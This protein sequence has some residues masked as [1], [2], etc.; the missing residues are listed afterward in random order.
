MPK[1]YFKFIYEKFGG[2]Y[3]CGVYS[4]NHPDQTFAK[5]GDLCID[6]ADFN[7]LE[8]NDFAI[9][10][11]ERNQPK[12][13]DQITELLSEIDQANNPK[14]I[15]PALFFQDST[16][17]NFRTNY[18]EEYQRILEKDHLKYIESRLNDKDK[19]TN[20]P[21]QENNNFLKIEDE[22]E[23]IE[24]IPKQKSFKIEK[25]SDGNLISR[26]VFGFSEDDIPE[27]LFFEESTKDYFRHQYFE[28]YDRI[29]ETRHGQRLDRNN[30]QIKDL[31]CTCDSNR[32]LGRGESG[33]FR[34][35][36]LYSNFPKERNLD[37]DFEFA[38][39]HTE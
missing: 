22:S 10:T 15:N 33:H 9:I 16:K 32:F 4:S 20:M 1:K 28:Q 38:E 36:P 21:T 27:N 2:H 11:Q 5:L 6:E 39:K 29:L 19:F 30:L 25:Y 35:C 18:P 12:S 37:E 13:S 8:S 3:H 34:S 26:D 24:Q 7:A 14:D 17:E 23:R 31:K